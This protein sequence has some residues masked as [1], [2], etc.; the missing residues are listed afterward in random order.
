MAP[1]SMAEYL[2]WVAMAVLLIS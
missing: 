1:M 2:W